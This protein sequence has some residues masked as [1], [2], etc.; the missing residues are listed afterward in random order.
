MKA[1]LFVHTVHCGVRVARCVEPLE[2]CKCECVS[3][4]GGLYNEF[5]STGLGHTATISRQ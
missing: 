3:G 4:E 5:P 2:V 1:E